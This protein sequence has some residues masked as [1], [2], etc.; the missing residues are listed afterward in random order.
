MKKQIIILLMVL[1]ASYLSA[2]NP[3]D[4]RYKKYEGRYGGNEGICLFDDGHFLLYGYATAVFGTYRFEKDHLLFYPDKPE[5]FEVFA[6]ENRS[7]ADS[8]SINFTGFEDGTTFAQF[9]K[10]G[11]QRVFN[12][13]ANCFDAPF[14]YKRAH[15]FQ[16][17]SLSQGGGEQ[18]GEIENSNVSW[19]YT[20]APEYNDFIVIYNKPKSVYQDFAALVYNKD[21]ELWLKGDGYQDSDGFPRKYDVKDDKEWPAIVDWKDQYFK[22]KDLE[23]A[24]F[25]NRHYNSFPYP[26]D[27]AY[28]YDAKTN[29]YIS[30]DYLENEEYYKQNE[31]NDDR[32]LRKYN[33]LQSGYQERFDYG[34]ANMASGSMFYTTCEEPD[35]SYKY[36]GLKKIDSAS[37]EAIPTT[38]VPAPILPNQ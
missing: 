19:L 13:D 21:G 17:L 37:D 24:I 38:T 14:V 33:K 4:N 26:D 25:A 27:Q 31:Y 12:Q 8:V 11:I 29:Q 16:Q 5:L 34:Q 6:Y 15:R 7:L 2:Q 3:N 32:F 30:K 20:I 23:D 1:S 10:G 22:K 28:D 36:N 9:D 18:E 35:K